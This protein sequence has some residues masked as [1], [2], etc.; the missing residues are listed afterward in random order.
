MS[1]KN[2]HAA[3]NRLRRAYY[4]SERI[5]N[6]SLS[7]LGRMVSEA[8]E[9]AKRYEGTPEIRQYFFALGSFISVARRELTEELKWIEG[10]QQLV[11]EYRKKA[12]LET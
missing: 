5:K 7:D 1:R 4:G 9:E 2:E 10:F 3:L 6:Y 11:E 12:M 8:Y